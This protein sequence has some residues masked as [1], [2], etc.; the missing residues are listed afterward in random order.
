MGF[1]PGKFDQ[2]AHVPAPIGSATTSSPEQLTPLGGLIDTLSLAV[3]RL[4]DRAP[5]SAHPTDI[6]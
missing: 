4:K 6:T 1:A 2:K 3:D 5:C